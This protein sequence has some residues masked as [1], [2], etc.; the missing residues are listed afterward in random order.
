[1]ALYLR[2]NVVFT[3]YLENQLVEIHQILNMYLSWQNLV[4]LLDVILLTLVPELCPLI[5][6]K[7]SFLL[8]ILRTN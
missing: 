5:D 8:N 7:I 2:Q 1:M 6:T 3:Q 4:F